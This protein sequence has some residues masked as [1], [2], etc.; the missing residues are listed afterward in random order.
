[1]VREGLGTAE[2]EEEKRR[3]FTEPTDFLFASQVRSVVLGWPRRVRF[4]GYKVWKF[5][6]ESVQP[7]TSGT[8]PTRSA[9]FVV[10]EYLKRNTNS[11]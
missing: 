2:A 10:P 9:A 4:F 5:V 11:V 7:L 3:E 1:M 8:Y 6:P